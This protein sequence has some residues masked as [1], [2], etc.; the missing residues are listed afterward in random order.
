MK[1]FLRLFTIVLAL[2]MVMTF[3][4]GCSQENT[5]EVESLPKATTNKT[6]TFTNLNDYV[7]WVKGAAEDDVYYMPVLNENV[8]LKSIDIVGMVTY[9]LEV[10]TADGKTH[11]CLLTWTMEGDGYVYLSKTR[12]ELKL[13]NWYGIEEV[14]GNGED[15]DPNIIY[16]VYDNHAFQLVAP[17]AMGK[18]EISKLMEVEKKTA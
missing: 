15:S 9:N 5:D 1:R 12:Q 17:A 16:W 14:Y 3:F 13:T 10:K 18:D 6:I 11:S 4:S 2:A 8:K 7:K